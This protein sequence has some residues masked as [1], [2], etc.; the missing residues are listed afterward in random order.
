MSDIQGLK[1]QLEAA[2]EAEKLAAA[3]AACDEAAKKA[4]AEEEEAEGPVIVEEEYRDVV[5]AGPQGGFFSRQ[6]CPLFA[7]EMA[8]LMYFHLDNISNVYLF[9]H[10]S[11]YSLLH[12]HCYDSRHLIII[13]HKRMAI[14]CDTYVIR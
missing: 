5:M 3:A 8:A 14:G 4:A 13:T 7:A 9:I 12:K 11:P 6:V 2:E 1:K 10:L